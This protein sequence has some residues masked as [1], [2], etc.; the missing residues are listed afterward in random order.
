[1]VVPKVSQKGIDCKK[2]FDDNFH[3]K[4]KKNRSQ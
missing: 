4:N 3:D 2:N 1:M